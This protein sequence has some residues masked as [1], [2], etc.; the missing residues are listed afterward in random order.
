MQRSFSEFRHQTML[1]YFQREREMTLQIAV[2]RH[3]ETR[4]W[5]LQKHDFF[6]RMHRWIIERRPVATLHG[7]AIQVA[8]HFQ[9]R[10]QR[11]VALFS[12]NYL[13]TLQSP[14]VF[15]IWKFS[16]MVYWILKPNYDQLPLRNVSSLIIWLI[17]TKFVTGQ[18]RKLINFHKFNLQFATHLLDLQSRSISG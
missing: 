10:Q 12:A 5:H 9:T 8:N 7:Q 18:M 14:V 6:Q 3:V 17:W 15:E 4:S 11:P 16:R 13:I 2:L 1:F